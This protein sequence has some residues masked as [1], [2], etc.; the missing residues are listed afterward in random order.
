MIFISPSRRQSENLT[1]SHA[2]SVARNSHAPRGNRE[3][4]HCEGCVP[5]PEMQIEGREERDQTTPLSNKKQSPH[6]AWGRSWSRTL[7]SDL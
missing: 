2:L 5:K 6:A 7:T 4:V 3:C 1:K